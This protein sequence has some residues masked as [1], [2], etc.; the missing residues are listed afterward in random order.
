MKEQKRIKLM[1]DRIGIYKDF[2]INLFYCVHD[3]YI[4]KKS[5]VDST[6]IRNHFNWCFN[7]VNDEF[8]KEEINFEDNDKLRNYLFSY[9]DPNFYNNPTFNTKDEVDISFFI[10]FWNTIFNTDNM[11]NNTDTLRTL[12]ELYQLFDTTINNK[13]KETKVLA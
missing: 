6:D 12:V 10:S 7:R 4:D 9:Y 5:L 13:K 8:K 11:E 3:F 2:S 1:G